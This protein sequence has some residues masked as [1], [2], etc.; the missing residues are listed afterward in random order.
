GSLGLVE[1]ARPQ[2]G[3]DLQVDDELR[4]R[5]CRRS[6]CRCRPGIQR[7]LEQDPIRD[8]DRY[9]EPGRLHRKLRRDREEHQERQR[10]AGGTQLSG[11]V[12]RGHREPIYARF[13]EEA[14]YSDGPVSVRIG[15][16]D[17][18][19]PDTGRQH[20]SDGRQVRRKSVQVD[21]QP[22]GPRQRRQP[23]VSERHLDRGPRGE[24]S[25]RAQE[26]RPTVGGRDASAAAGLPAG[27]GISR[28]PK[29]TG[30]R[31]RG[32]R[33]A[34]RF[35]AK[36]IWS[37]RSDASRPASPMRSRT[38]SP[39]RPWRYTPRRAAAKGSRP[40]ASSAPIAPAR[41][42][43]VPPLAMAGFSNGAT[44]TDPSGAAMTVRAPLRT[45]TWPHSSAAARVTR[46]RAASSATR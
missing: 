2:P 14:G 24:G 23:R 18:L 42:S 37:G 17:G 28:M 29:P 11:L 38:A 27:A 34:R 3:L 7:P 9:V 1:A 15:L 21:G 46:A 45:T 12:K 44:A 26:R 16:D 32:A 41:T 4:R 25:P 20:G 8:R 6:G 5:S 40:W 31:D 39:A 36:A 10:Y 19:Q 43:P 33:A 22:R 13:S 35:R 30:L